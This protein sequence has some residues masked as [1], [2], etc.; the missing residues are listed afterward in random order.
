[1]SSKR[2]NTPTKLPKEELVKAQSTL[3]SNGATTPDH[4]DPEEETE[5]ISNKD[6]IENELEDKADEDTEIDESGAE[7]DGD[8]ESTDARKTRGEV[9]SD[10]EFHVVEFPIVSIGRASPTKLT[11]SGISSAAEPTGLFNSH[12]RSMETVL[13]RLNSKASDTSS[14]VALTSGV[15]LGDQPKVMETVQAVLAGEATL[16]EKERQISEMINHLQN[17]RENLNKQKDQVSS[18]LFLKLDLKFDLQ[19]SIFKHHI[20][21]C[22]K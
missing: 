7:K 16:S 17:I 21:S 11:P 9:D 4:S 14:E 13:R 8:L 12:K 20:L 22:T 2:K 6:A 18:F 19:I 3:D 1:M 10:N 15:D 5:L